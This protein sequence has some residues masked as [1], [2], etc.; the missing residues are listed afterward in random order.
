M[1][2]IFHI[3]IHWHF[4]LVYRIY[5]PQLQNPIYKST[6]PTTIGKYDRFRLKRTRHLKRVSHTRTQA[7]DKKDAL[8]IVAGRCLSLFWQLI[9]FIFGQNTEAKMNDLYY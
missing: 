4:A 5:G 9:H 3:K 6:H 8:E 2:G 7:T 1:P